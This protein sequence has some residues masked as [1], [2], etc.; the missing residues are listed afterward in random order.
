MYAILSD[1]F[2]AQ[3]ILDFMNMNNTL[4]FYDHYHLK[5][6]LGKKTTIKIEHNKTLR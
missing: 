1:E 6:N 3:S 4:I 5:L 2:L